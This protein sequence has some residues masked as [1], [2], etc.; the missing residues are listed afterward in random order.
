MNKAEVGPEFEVETLDRSRAILII[1]F[2]LVSANYFVW[3]LGPLMKT[4]MCF[5]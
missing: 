2:L 3:R 4:P 5:H 1:V